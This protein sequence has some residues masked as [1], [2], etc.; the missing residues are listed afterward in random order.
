VFG[1]GWERRHPPSMPHFGLLLFALVGILVVIGWT[2]WQMR[3]ARRRDW[4]NEAATSMRLGDG[5]RI[6]EIL[7]RTP[8]WASGLEEV[9][10]EARERLG[11]TERVSGELAGELREAERIFQEAPVALFVVDGSGRIEQANQ[12]ALALFE[13]KPKD[14]LGRPFAESC[15]LWE[16]R[17]TREHGHAG[18][19]WRFAQVRSPT[20]PIPIQLW[21]HGPQADE[22]RIVAAFETAP[23][24]RV[25][26]APP[27]D[28][29]AVGRFA[30]S[31]AHDFNDLLTAVLGR[32]SVLISECEPA[33]P[34]HKDLAEIVAAGEQ[35]RLLTHQLLALSRQNVVGRA[36]RGTHPDAARSMARVDLPCAPAPDAA[37]AS[38]AI[39]ATICLVEDDEAVKRF[40]AAVLEREG[41]AVIEA[42][43]GPDCLERCRAHAGTIDLLVS[44]VHM[45]SMYGTE[46]YLELLR[47]RPDLEAVF[48][49]GFVERELFLA[50]LGRDCEFL[51]K[52]FTALELV[53]R[54][55]AALKR[56]HH[57]RP[58]R[59]LVV[60]DE[61]GT[62]DR[63][64]SLLQG[65]GV[66]VTLA[67]DGREALVAL[68]RSVVDAVICEMVMP[69]LDGVQICSE[70]RRRWPGTGIVAMTGQSRGGNHLAVARGLGAVSELL[71][72]FSKD[73]LA[74]ALDRAL[75]CEPGRT[76]TLV[77]GGEEPSSRVA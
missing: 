41:H 38:G 16:E 49:S 75:G 72:P 69:G 36:P 28:L 40:V 63:L 50:D 10:L 5:E 14:L 20:G 54:V 29:E 53:A 59:V 44:D 37:D 66:H 42:E 74:I 61:E 6:Q 48:M 57:S 71:K 4:A 70:I 31:V 33:S 52:P 8:S 23:I 55:R 19:G 17:S 12:R 9:L 47:T 39:H 64:N 30:G 67:R 32:A 45:P 22:R 27:T 3:L 24:G 62:R 35:A 46:L 13:R 56:R 18:A 65:L 34:L 2:L 68:E 60:D 76:S 15:I 26:E 11:R 77:R 21:D 73:E 7:G 25:R 1:P 58:A 43:N 51:Q